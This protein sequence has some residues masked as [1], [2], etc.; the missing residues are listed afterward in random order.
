MPFIKLT[1]IERKRI[2]ILLTCLVCAILA[3]LFLALNNKYVYS[4]KTQLIYK[5]EPQK[6][7]FKALQPNVVD[8]QVEGTGWQLIFS[9]LRIKPS[10]ISVSLQK[11]NTHNFILLSDQLSKINESIDTDQKCLTG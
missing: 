3:W 1:K 8:L 6:K 2:A 5:D 4:V 10:A 7:A 9:R 11:L